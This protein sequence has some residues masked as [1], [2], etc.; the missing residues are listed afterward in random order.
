MHEILQDHARFLQEV[1]HYYARFSARFSVK[2]VQDLVS[3]MSI[4]TC[5]FHFESSCKNMCRIMQESCKKT[6][7]SLASARYV[8]D[9][10]QRFLQE[11]WNL[12]S[13]FVQD[14]CKFLHI[15]ARQ[16]YLGRRSSKS[17]GG[18]QDQPISYYS[19]KLLDR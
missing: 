5:N 10:M 8:Q 14:S 15:L 6:D 1:K 3:C 16:F 9:F 2:I 11:K 7:V 13:N 12:A 4:L 19:R 18:D 17:R